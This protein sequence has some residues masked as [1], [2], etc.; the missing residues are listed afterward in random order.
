MSG[1]A[2]NPS[3]TSRLATR[4]ATALCRVPLRLLLLL[5]LGGFQPV[6]LRVRVRVR[7]RVRARVRVRGRGRGRGRIRVR[8]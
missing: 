1:W 7:V 2:E 8:V 5:S 6:R 3:V 4:V